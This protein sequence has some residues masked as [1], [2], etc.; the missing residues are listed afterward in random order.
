MGLKA[1]VGAGDTSHSFEGTI[2]N[3]LELE[4]S[5]DPQRRKAFLSNRR[6]GKRNVGR[7]ME[8]N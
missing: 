4:R 3:K 1:G 2:L 6:E 8:I 7:R 5:L